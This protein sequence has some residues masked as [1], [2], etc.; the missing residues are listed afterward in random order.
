M[1]EGDLFMESMGTVSVDQR[2][3]SLWLVSIAG[4]HDLSNISQLTAA[5]DGISSIG[6]SV[7]VDLSDATFIDSTVI[8]ALITGCNRVEQDGYDF[9]LVVPDDSFTN[10]V[11]TI[12][13]VGVLLGMCAS[14]KDA[15]AIIDEPTIDEAVTPQI[16]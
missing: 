7:I 11:L 10:R 14:V 6:G 16:S 12:A 3:P 4:E 1:V 15:I 9:S 2:G 8:R 13:G 5:F